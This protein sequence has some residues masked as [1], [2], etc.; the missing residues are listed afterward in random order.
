MQVVFYIFAFVFGAVFG[1]FLCCQAWRLRLAQKKKGGAGKRSI[2]LSCKKQLK[3]YD[4]IPI[5]SWLVL[6]G[7]C[8]YCGK[9]IGVSEILAE[10]LTGVVF[11]GLMYFFL[12]ICGGKVLLGEPGIQGNVLVW[13]NCIVLVLLTLVFVFL[14]I[15]DGKWGELP[16]V[17]LLI[18]IGIG[19][20]YWVINGFAVGFSMEYFWHTLGAT[21]VLAGLYE[22]LY[23]VSRGRWVGDGDALLC[24]PIALVLGNV[25]LA[26]FV[27]FI[28]NTLGCIYA[29]PMVMRKKKKRDFKIYFGPFLVAAFFI[30]LLFSEQILSLMAF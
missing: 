26:V 23:L 8:R 19:V 17:F 5:I 16:T 3:W 15:Y 9:K 22:L 25:W 28:A 18:A 14:S 30:V 7:K 4:N 27:L 24:I 29:L 13:I 6:R 11:V 12:E 1:S 2:C 20:I 10:V 21:A